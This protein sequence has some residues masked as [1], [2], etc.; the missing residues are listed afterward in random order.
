MNFKG[1]WMIKNDSFKKAIN[2][3]YT[4]NWGELSSKIADILKKSPNSVRKL[5]E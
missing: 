3:K 1:L 4:F 2:M 5:E